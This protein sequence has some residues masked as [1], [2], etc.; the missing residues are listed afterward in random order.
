MNRDE[1]KKL[2]HTTNPFW[3]YV[4]SRLKEWK[5]TNNV[6]GLVDIH[7]RDDTQ[8]VREY[9][10]KYY[11]RWGCEED[12]SFEYGKYVVFMP[13][14]EHSSYHNAGRV[15]SEEH[16]KKISQSKQGV[17][18]P[19]HGKKLSESTR[20]KISE[21][22]RGEK[23]HYYGKHPSDET[24]KKLSEVHK[25]KPFSDDHKRKI[26]ENNGSKRPDVRARKSEYMKSMRRLFDTHKHE[27]GELKWNEFLH[28]FAHSTHKDEDLEQFLAK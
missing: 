10:S 14:G 26:S 6:H 8:D 28:L 21:A 19:N 16:K 24:R 11:E 7:H 3:N 12:G 15:F 9:N 17:N 18:H 25:G 13:H 2:G 22:Q 23:N 20:K 5:E 27:G 1:W 4:R